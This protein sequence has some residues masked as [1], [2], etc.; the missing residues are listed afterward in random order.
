MVLS[1]GNF[2]FS[3]LYAGILD[4]DTTLILQPG[5]G[6]LFPAVDFQCVIYSKAEGSAHKDAYRE[7]IKVTGISDDTLTIVRGQEG[8]PAKSWLAGDKIYNPLTA[9]A[10]DNINAGKIGGL[11]G[12]SGNINRII[13]ANADA[14]KLEYKTISGTT[15][16]VSIAHAANSI[17]LSTPQNIHT[18]ASPIFDG[19]TLNNNLSQADAK[20]ISTDEIR[21]RDGDGLKLFDDSGNGIFVKDGGQ[22]G[23]G[24]T[25]PDENVALHIQNSGNK[26]R[27]KL[28]D[29]DPREATIGYSGLSDYLAMDIKN[30]V[31]FRDPA[32]S[33]ANRF[34]I[35]NLGNIGFGTPDQFGGGAKVLSIANAGTNPSSNPTDAAIIYSADAAGAGS[36]SIHF[37]N[38]LGHVIKMTQH[39]GIVNADGSLADI[40]TKFN[41]LLAKFE[42]IGFLSVV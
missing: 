22:I 41:A 12:V 4:S 1:I 30:G 14:S 9:E 33:Y 38:E 23:I 19:L 31:V 3:T 27:I 39:T 32:D 8:T 15:N 7:I 34:C 5:D 2:A 17:T 25:T 40:T 26:T 16:Q 21:A 24:M 6:S 29:S 18:G 42:A 20:Y 10:I 28:T 36:A 35:D 13:G 11:P 37:R